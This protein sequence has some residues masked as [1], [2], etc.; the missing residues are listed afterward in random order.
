[1]MPPRV[2]HRIDISER[3]SV[4]EAFGEFGKAVGP[5]T[6]P[7]KRNQNQIDDFCVRRMILG[8]SASRNLPLPKSIEMLDPDPEGAWPDALLGWQDGTISGLEITT[9]TSSEYQEQLTREE[10]FARTLPEGE[11]AFFDASVDGYVGAPTESIAHDVS[12]AIMLKGRPRKAGTK[13]YAVPT[14]DLLIYESSE[15]GLFVESRDNEDVSKVVLDLRFGKHAP[16]A[17]LIDSF[18]HVNL[19]ISRFF[20]HSILGNT[21]IFRIDERE[22][23]QE[24]AS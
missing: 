16:A 18:R 6:G 22:S 2:R 15:G 14:C 11:I 24:A 9:A 1:M 21:R 12:K 5:R 19:L 20:V 4:A 3:T 23:L 13:Y 8:L 7:G 17:E 10:R